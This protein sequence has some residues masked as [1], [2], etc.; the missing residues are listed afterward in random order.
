MWPVVTKSC[1]ADSAQ[2]VVDLTLADLDHSVAARADEAAVV[3]LAA[4]EI[5]RLSVVIGERI[6]DA[7]LA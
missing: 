5:T 1:C 2:P 6:D 7:L 3:R 4:E